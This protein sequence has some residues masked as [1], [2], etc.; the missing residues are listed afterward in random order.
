PAQPGRSARRARGG[1]GDPHRRARSRRLRAPAG[2]PRLPRP[3][4]LMRLRRPRPNAYHAFQRRLGKNLMK[5]ARSPRDLWASLLPM[6]G[7]VLAL[8]VASRVRLLA[9]TGVPS[10]GLLLVL[11][12]AGTAAACH[13]PLSGGPAMPGGPV[14]PGL[15][16]VV[17]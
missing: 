13:R 9:S 14:T 10:P 4:T 15:G 2:C 17:L 11:V 7:A 3:S 8:A 5:R 16:A 6:A 12:F 1:R